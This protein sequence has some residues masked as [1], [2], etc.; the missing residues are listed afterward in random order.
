MV[1]LSLRKIFRQKDRY[2]KIVRFISLSKGL[3]L[4]KLGLSLAILIFLVGNWVQY[5]FF[6]MRRGFTYDIGNTFGF[7]LPFFARY[8]YE[9]PGWIL[10]SRV[11]LDLVALLLLALIISWVL[12]AIRP[13]KTR[14]Q[15]H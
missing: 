15:T 13:A 7:P 9:E 1:G 4:S 14:I 3:P 6:Y 10:W 12:R 2:P 8:R 5:C 11:P